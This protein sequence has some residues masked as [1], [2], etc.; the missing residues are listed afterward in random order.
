MEI[1]NKEF[2]TPK[3]VLTTLLDVVE[4]EKFNDSNASNH[5]LILSVALSKSH[6]DRFGHESKFYQDLHHLCQT[7]ISDQKEALEKAKDR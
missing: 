2:W 5:L 6:L 7:H 4:K 3:E 1:K